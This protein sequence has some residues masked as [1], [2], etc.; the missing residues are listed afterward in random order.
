MALWLGFWTF[1]CSGQVSVIGV[2]TEILHA[3]QCG[4]LQ[5]LMTS[6]MNYGKLLKRILIITVLSK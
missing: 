4:Q 3:E 2:G 6:S 5:N 1:Y